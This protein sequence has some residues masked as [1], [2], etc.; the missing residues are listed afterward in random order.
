MHQSRGAPKL[1]PRVLQIPSRGISPAGWQS[2][3]GPRKAREKVIRPMKP[4]S[5]VIGL[6]REIQYCASAN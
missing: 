6:S 5:L 3:D 1:F 2:A 4:I